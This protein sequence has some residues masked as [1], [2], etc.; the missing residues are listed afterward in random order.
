MNK[1]EYSHDYY[2][3]NKDKISEYKKQWYKDKNNLNDELLNQELKRIHNEIEENRLSDLSQKLF[4]QLNY[5]YKNQIIELM[6][7][8]II[9]QNKINRIIKELKEEGKE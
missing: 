5:E 6:G 8:M 1:K 3:K 2:L 4:N 7:E 9:F